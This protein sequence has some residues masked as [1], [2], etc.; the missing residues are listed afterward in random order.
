MNVTSNECLHDKGVGIGFWG[1]ARGT[2][3]SNTCNRDGSGASGGLCVTEHANVTLTGN[4]CDDN[5]NY[6]IL[7]R[8]HARGVV[9]QNECS[10]NDY[11]IIITSPASAKL[12]GNTL[13]W[14]TTQAVGRW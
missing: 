6:G 10:G 11:G 2:A 1:S 5:A 12:V 4:Q 9:R 13:D 8:D 7:F 14:N 3:S